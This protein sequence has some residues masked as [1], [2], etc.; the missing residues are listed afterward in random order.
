[1]HEAEVTEGE[2]RLALLQAEA[3]QPAPVGICHVTELQQQI[4]ALVR[5]REALRASPVK[6]GKW[7]GNGPPSAENIPAMLTDRQDLEGWLS[8]RCD[9]RNAME[10][11]ERIGGSS[12]V[13]SDRERPGFGCWV[14]TATSPWTANPDQLSCQVLSTTKPS[15]GVWAQCRGVGHSEL[16]NS[17][18]GLRGVRVG[19]ASNPGP[20]RERNLE[21]IF[22][23]LEAVLTWLDSS[24]EE[25]LVRPVS[26]WNVVRRVSDAASEAFVICFKLRGGWFWPLSL[27]EPHGLCRVVRATGSPFWQQIRTTKIF[28]SRMAESTTIPATPH[29]LHEAGVLGPSA[30][31]VDDL[32]CDLTRVDPDD[33]RGSESRK[34]IP[35]RPIVCAMSQG[36]GFDAESLTDVVPRPTRRRLVMVSSGEVAAVQGAQREGDVCVLREAR[37]AKTAPQSEV[38][39]F[40]RASDVGRC[41]SAGFQPSL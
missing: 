34:R 37:A 14:E 5:D 7:T 8:D 27:Q 19:E 31:L 32:E 16:I 29:A 33:V 22:S 24:D 39:A 18:H 17:R 9:L 41:Q 28:L 30:T 2:R 26:G 6:D 12:V 21:E 38:V 36:S 35:S 3:A 1:M 25:P 15:G 23:E 13:W 20:A 11:G 4:D 10:F 40:E